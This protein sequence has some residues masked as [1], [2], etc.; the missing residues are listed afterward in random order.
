MILEI[1]ALMR[2]MIPQHVSDGRVSVARIETTIA[3]YLVFNGGSLAPRWAVRIGPDDSLKRTHAILDRLHSLAETL[4]PQSLLCQPWRGGAWVQV[5]SGVPGRPW[6]QLR[7]YL[8]DEADWARVRR[9]A[10]HS[11]DALHSAIKCNPDWVVPTVDLAAEMC[12]Q[13]DASNALPIASA[14]AARAW[15]RWRDALADAPSTAWFWQHGDFCLNNLIFSDCAA[16][17]I[18]FDEFG[19][20]AMP[21]HDEFGLALSFMD[22]MPPRFGHTL[23]DH[24]AFC[25]VEVLRREPSL[26]H[27]LEGL[28]LHHLLWR[29]AHCHAHKNRARALERL[30]GLLEEHALRLDRLFA[31]TRG[32][33]SA[34]NAA[35]A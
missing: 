13:L 28:F 15:D 9:T 29:I 5:Q 18:D 25:L 24:L 23:A 35:P 1:P 14:L 21:L 34:G 12:R 26:T 33:L 31:C 17:V 27:Q 22:L 32:K 8:A 3:V 11:L 2:E 6:F 7:E 16:A 19:L 30:V 20:T 10:L 4:V